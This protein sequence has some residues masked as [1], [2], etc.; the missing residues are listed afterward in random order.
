MKITILNT[1]DISGGAARAM[2]RLH[3]GLLEI[4]QESRVISVQKKSLDESVLELDLAY[5]SSDDSPYKNPM[6]ELIQEMIGKKRTKLSNTLFSFPYPDWDIST[7]PWV[8]KS[9]IIS[10]HWVSFFLSPRSIEQLISLNKPVVWTLHDEWAFTGGC[11]YTAGCEGF[12]EDCKVCPQLDIPNSK[13]PSFVLQEKL[14]RFQDNITIISPT[15]WL[16]DRARKSKLFRNSRIEVIP[17]SL[18]TSIFRPTPKSEAKAN[19]NISAETFTML[20]GTDNG[21]ERRKGFP[22]LLDALKILQN[23]PGWKSAVKSGKIRVLLFGELSR[24]IQELGIPYTSLGHT[25]DDSLLALAYSAA[26]LFILPSLEDN[27]PNTMLEALS[28]ETPIVAFRTGGMPDMVIPGR[29]GWLAGFAKPSSLAENIL[30]AYENPEERQNLGYNGRRWM[31]EKFNLPVQANRYASLFEELLMS[32]ST[33][34]KANPGNQDVS[35]KKQSFSFPESILEESIQ[36]SREILLQGYSELKRLQ[37]LENLTKSRSQIFFAEKGGYDYTKGI[38]MIISSS[39][40]TC[41]FHLICGINQVIDFSKN[42]T[43]FVQNPTGVTILPSLRNPF[44]IYIEKIYLLLKGG[45]KIELSLDDI[46]GNWTVRTEKYL[47]FY[48]GHGILQLSWDQQDVDGVE[49]I[50]EWTLF[51]SWEAFDG[52]NAILGSRVNRISM[53]IG[54]ALM[55]PLR[56]VLGKRKVQIRKE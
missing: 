34:G 53:K 15:I 55:A 4:G 24:D 45:E 41:R 51:N 1:H 47:I 17:N 20:F 38:Q 32:P 7:H 42:T 12:L 26:D 11:H 13:I 19:W 2:Y 9:D 5:K 39:T 6:S 28:C 37:S 16:A 8:Q 3:K 44:K 50:G 56:W 48:H 22:E 40:K 25:K 36:N 10:L 30:E 35:N 18:D 14:E 54:N 27:L 49:L 31:E 23:N 29:T 21:N 33:S 46:S 52:L 43:H